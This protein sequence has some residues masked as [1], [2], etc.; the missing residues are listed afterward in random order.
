MLVCSPHFPTRS[1]VEAHLF[2]LKWSRGMDSNRFDQLTR[3]L[4]ARRS[5]RRALA[6]GVGG[7]SALAL[8]GRVLPAMAQEATPAA[9]TS[10][11]TTV[12]V[13]L[14]DEG[15]WTPKPEAPG[16]Y[17]LTLIEPGEQTLSFTMA[18]DKFVATIR[19][20]DLL[21]SLGFTPEFPPNA[22]V[23]VVTPDGERDVLVV[24]L[25]DPVYTPAGGVGTPA[26]LTYEARVLN[27]YRGTGLQE[28]AT[29]VEDDQLPTEFEQVSLFI[30]NG[31]WGYTGCYLVEADGL[32]GANVGQ[33]PGTPNLA[34]CPG[35]AP[36]TC[37]PCGGNN[38]ATL[39]ARC[40]A[41][42]ADC[43]GSCIAD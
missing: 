27:A 16:V 33:V 21:E 8:G 3:T 35:V 1:L 30:D 36:G 40:N 41:A 20:E 9:Q 7:L 2:G 42:Y 31:C 23:E 25:M 26:V 32:R 37:V 14:A 4:G 28:W 15:R 17:L 6:T 43:S 39:N 5:R 18:P 19:T 29:D 38:Q 24:E 13:Q 12:Y 10:V 34:R 22:A 11:P